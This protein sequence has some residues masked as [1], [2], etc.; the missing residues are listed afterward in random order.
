MAEQS[1]ALEGIRVIELGSLIAGPFAG[2]ILAD[3]GAEVIKVE[4]VTGDPLRKYG[5]LIPP[6]ETSYWFAVQ[7]RN[8]KL[9]AIN[10]KDP[11]GQAIARRLIATADVVVENF[12]PGRLEGWNLAPDDLRRMKPELIIARISG[13]GQ[14][15]PYKRMPGFGNIAEAMGGIRDLT[16]YPDQPPA[17]TAIS[18]GDA[19]AGLFTSFA[20]LAALNARRQTGV[21]NVIDVSLLEAVFALLEGAVP[22][23]VHAGVVR[24]RLGTKL[25][26]AAPSGVYPTKD[27]RWISIGANGDGLFIRFADVIGRP[28][29]AEDPRLQDNVGRVAHSDE[30]DR[31]IGDWTASHALEDLRRQ[32]WDA[33]I[34]AGPVYDIRDIVADPH[35]QA[36]KAFIEVASTLAAHSITM[37]GVVPLFSDTPG[38][39]RWGGGRL[40]EHTA[41]VLRELVGMTAQELAHMRDRGVVVL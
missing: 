14:T 26:T 3:H 27:G 28:D 31:A 30:L 13:F 34:P 15:G 36:R 19:V 9:V 37:P 25:P 20:V 21:G 2:R 29:W 38:T 41:V 16:G 4:P 10:L 5:A 40:G 12:R 1:G 32:L 8:K 7:A 24:R 11:E 35:Y 18:L 39:V 6:T 33:G 23:Y 17:R 22:E